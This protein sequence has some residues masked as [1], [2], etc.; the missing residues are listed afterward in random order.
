MERGIK[1][2]R[3]CS[4]LIVIQALS[5]FLASPLFAAESGTVRLDADVISFEESTGIAKAD[6]NVRISDD[7]FHA[8]A[9]YL[10]YDNNSQW[11]T[12][13]SSPG[14]KVVTFTEGRRLE[15]D[16]LDYNLA[17]RRGVMINPTGKVDIFHVKG[18]E[19]EVMPSSETRADGTGESEEAEL[20]E[21]ELA[22]VWN[23][24]TLTTCGEPH[25]HYR[26]EAERVTI[27]PGDKMVLHRPKTFLGGTMLFMSP[28]DIAVSLRERHVTQF[29]PSVRYDQAKGVGLEAGTSV[30]WKDGSLLMDFVGWSK[31]IFEM[32][33]V[34]RHYLTPDLSLYAGVSRTYNK[35]MD[36]TDWRPRWGADYTYN[37]WRMSLGWTRRELLSVERKAGEVSRHILERN[38]EFNI[39]SPWFNDPAVYGRFRVFGV[40][41]NYRDIR[42]DD[43]RTYDRTGLGVQIAGQPGAGENITPFYDAAYTHYFYGDSA[44]SAQRILSASVGLRFNAGRFSSST[45]YLRQ[46]VWG[47]SP[48]SWDRHVERNEL[49]Q[50]IGVT[51]PTERVGYY[52]NLGLGGAYDFVSEQLTEMTYSV[53]YNHHCLLW[54]VVYKDDLIGK[55]DRMEVTLSINGLGRGGTGIL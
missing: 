50:E 36:E 19:I 43:S 3:F 52:W 45:T 35:D 25:P 1:L 11:I 9:P 47:Q 44:H 28:L 7:D 18:K 2:V 39:S 30:N 24:A 10:E 4:L 26:L 49:S 13:F 21:E 34:A 15:G 32:D 16:R 6:G 31:G 40:W 38:P 46:W 20:G 29:F 23:E 55:D 27:Y 12:A 53:G 8:T 54:E 51:I 42:R 22:A 5:V 37:G 14:Q 48:L 41:G 17:T 33:A